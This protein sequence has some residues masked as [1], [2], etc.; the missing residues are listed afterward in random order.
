VPPEPRVGDRP[1]VA[2][3]PGQQPD[4]RGGLGADAL[5]S[6]YVGYW[7]PDFVTLPVVGLAGPVDGQAGRPA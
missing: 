5:V 2:G 6:Q 4:G 7:Q 1:V 3:V